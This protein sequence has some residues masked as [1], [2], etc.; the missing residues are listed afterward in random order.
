[1]VAEA[2]KYNVKLGWENPAE[3]ETDTAEQTLYVSE[4]DDESF[5]KDDTVD[6]GE[7][8]DTVKGLEPGDYWFKLTQTDAAGNES[9]GVVTKVM[10]A[11]TGP[12]MLGLVLVSLGLGRLFRKKKA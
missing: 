11:E 6:S 4:G 3:N 2:Q 1:I 5:E 9:K 12:A 8:S 7:N 10:L